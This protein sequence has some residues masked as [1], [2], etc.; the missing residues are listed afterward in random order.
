MTERV[1]PLNA[2]DDFLAAIPAM[3]GMIPDNNIAVVVVIDQHQHIVSTLMTPMTPEAMGQTI[4]LLKAFPGPDYGMMLAFVESDLEVVRNTLALFGEKFVVPL[5]SLFF[6]SE[7]VPGAP[8]MEMTSKYTGHVPDYRD[9]ELTANAIMDGRRVNRTMKDI[10]NTYVMAEPAVTPAPTEAKDIHTR[11]MELGLAVHQQ[12]P[13]D[14]AKVGGLLVF[15]DKVRDSVLEVAYIDAMPAH[16]IFAEAGRKL[17]GQGRVEALTAAGL[18]AYVDGE[19][20]MARHAFAAAMVTAAMCE[21]MYTPSLAMTLDEALTNGVTPEMIAHAVFAEL[22][23]E[24]KN[25][26]DDQN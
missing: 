18:A 24:E 7:F 19:G 15:S 12:Q 4:D 8:Y 21:P 20:V 9:S 23:E 13:Y 11:I 17:R 22:Y 16:E 3:I 6:I 2:P 5:V 1:I 10:Y 14:P 25:F 26:D